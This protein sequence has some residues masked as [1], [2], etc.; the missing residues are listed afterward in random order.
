ENLELVEDFEQPDIT[1]VPSYGAAAFN[2]DDDA[3]REAYNEQLEEFQDTDEYV[4][5]LAD[6]Y[7][8]DEDNITD[9]DVTADMVCSEEVYENRYNSMMKSSCLFLNLLF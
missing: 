7:F 8:D 6:N 5:M 4:E 1:G 9:D 3:L 2:E